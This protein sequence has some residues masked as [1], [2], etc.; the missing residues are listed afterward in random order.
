MPYQIKYSD[1]IE[2]TDLRSNSI[3]GAYDESIQMNVDQTFIP[4]TLS[5]ENRFAP[6]VQ[7]QGTFNYDRSSQK[8]FLPVLW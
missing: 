2:A 6:D 8:S 1:R 5:A 3:F 7:E 4:G